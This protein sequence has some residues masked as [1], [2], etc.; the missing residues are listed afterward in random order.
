M[1]DPDTAPVPR[2]TSDRLYGISMRPQE[3]AVYG[4]RV[5][6]DL[7][8]SPIF[9]DEGEHNREHYKMMVLEIS[10]ELPP[11]D[12]LQLPARRLELAKCGWELS[13]E[14]DRPWP[15]A[16][17]PE[18]EGEVRHVLDRIADTINELA[19]RGGLEIPLGSQVVDRI[20]DHYGQI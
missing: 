11:D 18:L 15:S 17:L 14:T 7:R 6:F 1:N 3:L 16:L 13:L 9:D 5:Q 10:C 4:D 2:M 20:V 19:R 8:Y 12:E